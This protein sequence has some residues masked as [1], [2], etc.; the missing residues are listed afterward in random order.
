M[1]ARGRS[2]IQVLWIVTI[3][4][5]GVVVLLRVAGGRGG[6]GGED[7]GVGTSSRSGGPVDPT[8]YRQTI[9]EL[10]AI[11]YKA[12]PPGPGDGAAIGSTARR[13][14]E[15]V[16]SGEGPQH[17]TLG[18]EIVGFAQMADP[19]AGYGGVDLAAT[20]RRWEAAR[21]TVFQD[22]PWFRTGGAALTQAQSP[23]PPTAPTGV[24]QD[25]GAAVSLFELTLRSAR[26]S[27]MRMG[28]VGVDVTVG[29]PEHRELQERFN[30]WN[31]DFTDELNRV[32]QGM[33]ALPSGAE[34]N[35][36]MAHRELEQAVRY[37]AQL[38]MSAGSYG[39][40][41]VLTRESY[42]DAAEAMLQNTRRYLAQVRR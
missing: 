39:V 34:S 9:E 18:L 28:E 21:A 26:R 14:G 8:P 38:G 23:A 42:F 32:L 15:A 20:R 22:A 2:L 5:I 1:N 41:S 4:V 17:R 36:M 6:G 16:L 27:V 29:S 10:E 7:R 3:V 35:L 31:R 40:P 25:L 12:S 30:R 19:D 13:L 37:V 33:P 11:L 24:V